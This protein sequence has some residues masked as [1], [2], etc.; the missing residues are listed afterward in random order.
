MTILP[1]GMTGP[2]PSG[3]VRGHPGQG[4]DRRRMF[5]RRIINCNFRDVL[6]VLM[7]FIIFSTCG[8]HEEK[9]K[10]E[11]SASQSSQQEESSG[12]ASADPS[13]V[14]RYGAFL[15]FGYLWDNNHSANEMFRSRGTAY[16]VD[17]PIINIAGAYLHKTVSESSRWGTELTVQ[18]G[19]DTRVF[20]FSATA[21]NMPGY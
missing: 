20:G 7:V 19:Q 8:A 14:W 16:K 4:P 21:P 17:V 13:S 5:R 11:Q 12:I 18:A 9:S 1:R 2:R 15:D 10:N 3:F 6:P